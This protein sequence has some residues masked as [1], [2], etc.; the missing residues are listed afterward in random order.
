MVTQSI[1]A[2]KQP[3]T[4]SLY[5]SCRSIIEK[6]LL[7]PGIENYIVFTAENTNNNPLNKIWDICR[8]GIPLAALFNALSPRIPIPIDRSS[9]KLNDYLYKDSI[10]EFIKVL[11]TVGIVLRIL[12]EKNIITFPANND[13]IYSSSEPKDV[14]DKVVLELLETERKYVQDLEV[15]Q[16]YMHKLQLQFILNAEII[17]CLFGNLCALVDFQ[18]RLLIQLEDMAQRSPKDQNFGSL[19]IQ[20]EK[21]FT[22][23]ELY[24]SNY[25]SAQDM[26]SQETHR[27]Q[28]LANILNPV[29]ELSSMLIKPV[30]RICKYPL[31]IQELIKATR[32]DWPY[33][34]DIRQ[35]LESMRRVAERV[36]ETRRRYENALVVNEIKHR[37]NKLGS[38]QIDGFG[39]LLLHDKLSLFQC[40]IPE[41]EM[42]V[43][44][45]EKII[46]ICKDNSK[47]SIKLNTIPI[48]KKRRSNLEFRYGIFHSRILSVCNQSLDYGK[49]CLTVNWSDSK[50][51]N[52]T[53]W[54]RNQEYLELWE[55]M[56]KERIVPQYSNKICR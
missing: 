55:S 13:A 41:Q 28:R 25:F 24:C 36:N 7:V 4:T 39:S 42:Q 29:Y 46:L 33:A 6:L 21:R 22:V 2:I 40:G 43:Y 56:L 37:V 52:T 35:G 32:P 10:N 38:K 34:F 18:Q 5:H 1:I 27:L 17:H 48:R 54:F 11:N 15:L 20:N 26:A 45:F 53:F 3:C 12:E 30:Q 16:D 49:W 8:Q 44:L 31:L 9:T 50:I 23:Y 19:F 51:M 14:R 47:D